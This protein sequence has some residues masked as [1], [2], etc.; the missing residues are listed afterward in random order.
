MSTDNLNNSLNLLGVA[1][2]DLA[3]QPQPIEINDRDLSG[4]KIHGGLITQ[5]SSTGISDQASRMMVLVSDDGL[6]VDAIET[7]T[8]VGDTQVSGNLN[9]QGHITATSLH[10]DELTADIRN[11]RSESLDFVGANGDDVAGRGIVWRTDEYTRQFVFHRNPDRLFSTENIDVQNGRHY[12]IGSVPVLTDT[13]LGTGIT[14]SNLSSLGQLNELDVMGNVSFSEYMFWEASSERLGIGT[15]APNGTIGIANLDAEFIIDSE[16]DSGMRI[17]NFTNNDLQIITDDTTRLTIKANGS[18]I[19]GTPG[20]DTA[21]VNVYGK[22]GVGVTNVEPDV[23]VST[24]GPIKFQ[25]KKMEAGASIPDSGNY[26]QGDIVW[27]TNPQPTGYVGWICV[28][29]GTPGVWKPFGSI[30]K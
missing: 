12:S 24:A 8:L 10:V 13:A 21:R 3:N 17:G 19:A 23:S 14:S 18:I 20:A 26:M 29:D 5:F 4:N 25:G 28:R 30:G 15:E 6:T 27:N 22:I 1:I 11:E 9:V 7:D 16:S 2:A